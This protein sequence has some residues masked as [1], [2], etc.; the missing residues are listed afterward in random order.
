M[1]N[2]HPQMYDLLKRVAT[3]LVSA[4]QAEERGSLREAERLRS[5]ARRLLPGTRAAYCPHSMSA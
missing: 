3:L 1:R 4:R 5:D 2:D